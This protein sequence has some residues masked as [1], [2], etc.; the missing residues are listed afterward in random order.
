MPNVWQCLAGFL[1]VVTCHVTNPVWG[2]RL[3]GHPVGD[4]PQRV[5]PLNNELLPYDPN[6]NPES[7][8]FSSDGRVRVTVLTSKLFRIEMGAIDNRATLAVVHRNLPK[9]D[10]TVDRNSEHGLVVKTGSVELYYREGGGALQAVNT[11]TGQTWHLGQYPQGNLFGTIRTLDTLGPTNLNCSTFI[12]PD[13][14]CE[15]GLVSTEGWAVVDDTQT[16]RLAGPTDWWADVN[17]SMEKDLYLFMHGK[18]FK[19]AVSDYSKIG[20]RVPLP[21]RY[22]FGV[23]WTRWFD[24]DTADLKQLVN[25]FSGRGLP[26]DLLVIDMNWHTKPWW[27]G[28]TFDERIIP[29]PQG[30]AD[31]IHDQGVKVGLNIHDCL[32]AERGCPAGTLSTEDRPFYEQYT[33][34]LGLGAQQGNVQLDLVNASSALTK[35]DVVAQSFEGL[36]DMWWIDWQQGDSGPGGLKGGRENPTIWLNKLRYTN[37]KRWGSRERGSV[38]S[39]YGG[40]G[41]QRYGLG[42]SGDVQML[43]WENLSYQP[44]FTATGANVLFSSWSH[45]VTGPNRDPELFVRWTQW[46]AF[47]G[48]LRF[49]ERGMSSG[50]CAMSNFPMP[51]KECANVDLWANLPHRFGSVIRETTMTRLRFV[52]Y[53][54]TAAYNTYVDGVPWIRPLYYDFPDEPLAYSRKAQYMF[55]DI[56]TV[57]PVVLQSDPWAPTCTEWTIWAPPGLWYSPADGALVQGNSSY[58]R[59]WDVAEVPL[60]VK[61]GSFLPQRFVD[62]TQRL[63]GMAMTNYTDMVFEVIPGGTNGTARVYEDDGASVDYTDTD[64]T[65]WLVGEYRKDDSD[66]S[67]HVT[68]SVEGDF[69]KSIMNRRVRVR[70]LDSGPIKSLTSSTQS[71]PTKCYDGNTLEAEAVVDWDLGADGLS[72][73]L[74]IVP[75]MMH[76]DLSGIKGAMAHARFAKAAL[77]E[78]V[79]TPGTHP[80]WHGAPCGYKPDD[81]NLIRVASTGERLNSAKI[82]S[83]F[84]QLIREFIQRYRVCV[85]KEVTVD[86]ILRVD[87]AWAPTQGGWPEATRLRVNYAVAIIAGALDDVCTANP[88]VKMPLVCP[89]DDRES[90]EVTGDASSDFKEDASADETIVIIVNE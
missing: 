1:L 67:I 61:A 11:V 14:H 17:K 2:K 21:P 78:A 71:H 6:P 49:H 16:P 79:L 63:V 30:L 66:G 55:G 13:A 10:F 52:P 85:S 9:P 87:T 24:Y 39:R 58:T 32:L 57:A 62:S 4:R 29:D 89:P 74:T 38:L 48:V 7:V 60:L 59:H 5:P 8:V 77:D 76:L 28:Y 27:G 41:S 72:I 46:G 23:L 43:D 83:Q 70:L 56:I 31:W 90:D 54:Y 75:S 68:F 37:R 19:G 22:M 88:G 86:N 34:Q 12:D 47:S 25:G 40:L 45:D 69:S 51:A 82:E 20:G 42:F 53:I 65:G 80:C 44:F 15:Y 81:D 26:L 3:G 73:S 36:S 64:R 84:E 50:P 33:S 18:D 35:E